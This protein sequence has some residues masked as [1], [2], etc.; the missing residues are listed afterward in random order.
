MVNLGRVLWRQGE[1]VRAREVSAEAVA[2]LEAERDSLLVLAYGRLAAVDALGGRSAQGIEWA[3]KSIDL[4]RE[5]DY[6]NI[7]RP[8]GMR[9]VARVDLGDRGGID[10]LR[11]AVE[12]ALELDLPA[13]DT[14]IAYGNLGEHDEPR[15]SRARS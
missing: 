12:V 10:D 5:I 7:A 11:A 14:A 8:L 6:R 9:G 13:E 2:L 3:N 15:G 1:T 4:A